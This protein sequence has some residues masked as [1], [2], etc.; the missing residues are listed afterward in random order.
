MGALSRCGARYRTVSAADRAALAR[1]DG[2][3][4]RL[5]EAANAP[6]LAFGFEGGAN[7]ERGRRARTRRRGRER[8]ALVKYCAC[9]PTCETP[10]DIEEETRAS[11]ERTTRTDMTAYEVATLATS[12]AIGLGR[13]GIVWYG[14]R[15]MN[16]S[17]DERAKDRQQHARALDQLIRRSDTLIRQ[18]D[19]LIRQSDAQIR[20]LDAG[21]MALR[22]LIERSAPA[23]RG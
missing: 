1:D 8:G 11:G 23:D 3:G 21:T 9:H 18:S 10:A 6:D 16:R 2:V 5:T 22:T 15:A 14:I 19:T 13:I 12:V 17:T 20:Q 7:G 4:R